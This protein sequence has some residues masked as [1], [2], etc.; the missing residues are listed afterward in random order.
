MT[1][2]ITLFNRASARIVHEIVTA[3]DQDQ[4]E[5]FAKWRHMLTGGQWWIIQTEEAQQ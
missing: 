2:R 5:A 4:A 3:S 1:Y